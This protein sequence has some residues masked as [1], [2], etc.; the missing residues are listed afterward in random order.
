MRRYSA[1][2]SPNALH[3]S[4]LASSF[5]YFRRGDICVQLFACEIRTI[6]K[7]IYDDNCFCR[8]ERDSHKHNIALPKANGTHIHT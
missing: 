5:D 2:L 6:Y 4:L 7:I 1:A 8:I 3:T